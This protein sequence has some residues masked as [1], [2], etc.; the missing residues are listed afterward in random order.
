VLK[1]ID[2]KDK[3]MYYEVESYNHPLTKE[4]APAARQTESWSDM[5]QKK[6]RQ[7]N[8]L[9]W[10]STFLLIF[11]ATFLMVNFTSYWQI[12][13]YHVSQWQ[14]QSATEMNDLVAKAGKKMKVKLPTTETV[15]Q[16]AEEFPDM[17][18]DVNPPDNRLVVPK[19]N[20][21]VP[22]VEPDNTLLEQRRWA[23]LE[24]AINSKLK[25]GV[26]HYPHTAKP[27]ERGNMFLTGHSSYYLW[28]DG[29]YKDVFALLGVLE[30][31]DEFVI[32]YEGEKYAYKVTEKK[33][34]DPN[35]VEAMRQGKEQKATLMTCTPP[36]TRLRRLLVIGELQES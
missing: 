36:G 4:Q 11:M 22:I 28:D 16:V 33:E 31:G 9:A 17:N 15:Y 32:Y 25:T 29:R 27:Y 26:V 7:G 1:Y 12:G 10:V 5:S 14:G 35:H 34:V 30:V 24:D 18:L 6:P 8:L 19:I 3:N 23:E 2:T 20:K 13:S 21:N